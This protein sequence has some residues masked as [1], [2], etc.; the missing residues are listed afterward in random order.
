MLPLEQDS[1]V[2]LWAGW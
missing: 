2:R 1:L